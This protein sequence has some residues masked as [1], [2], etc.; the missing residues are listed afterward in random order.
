MDSR[1]LIVC[2]DGTGNIW[3]N[4]HDTNVVK[5]VRLL[6][7]DDR[8]VVYYDPGVGTTDN[9]PPIG[10]WNKVKAF[11]R[12]VM[13]LAMAGGI[14]ESIGQ[15]YEFLVDNFR[16]GDRVCLFGF[17]RGAFAARSIAGI[18]DQFGI[19]RPG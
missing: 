7:K 5:L 15:G 18:V 13:G 8:Q 1:N 16:A 6:V 9:F 14:Y 12:R 17:S 4:G 2:C 10:V 3:G 19:V 11:A